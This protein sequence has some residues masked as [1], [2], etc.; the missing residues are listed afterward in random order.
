MEIFELIKQLRIER[1][2]SQD[3]LANMVGYKDRSSIAKVEAGKVDLSQSK[4]AAFAKALG[5][6]PAYLH[7]IELQSQIDYIRN[8]IQQLQ[9]ALSGAPDY[10]RCD[11]ESA[12]STL[13]ES[14]D[15]LCFAQYLIGTQNN[16]KNHQNTSIVLKENVAKLFGR[17][18]SY[19]EKCVSD[20][21][22]ILLQS[23]LK[24]MKSVNE[25]E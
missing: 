23:M 25:S 13:E 18:G 12:I 11:I 10:D 16:K 5:V 2:L 8:N 17:D 6:T 1:G 14:Y 19:M 7:G 3:E 24:Q 4:I 22:L 15:D 9:A 21:Q 20:E